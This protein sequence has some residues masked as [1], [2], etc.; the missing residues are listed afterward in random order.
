MQVSCLMF[1]IGTVRVDGASRFGMRRFTGSMELT[2]M[3]TFPVLRGPESLRFCHSTLPFQGKYVKLMTNGV[4]E[5]N[6][7]RYPIHKTSQN[8]MPPVRQIGP[9]QISY[10]PDGTSSAMI[11]TEPY[12]EGQILDPLP[13]ET[14]LTG[15]PYEIVKKNDETKRSYFSCGRLKMHFESFPAGKDY[16]CGSAAAIDKNLLITAAHNFFPSHFSD[17]VANHEK[18]RAN[19]VNFEHLLLVDDDRRGSYHIHLA[20]HCYMHPEWEKSFDHRYDIALVFLSQ[21]ITLTQQES[22][23]LLK[24]QVLPDSVRGVIRIVGYPNARSMMRAST[25][26]LGDGNDASKVIY[27]RANTHG[28]S[29]SPIINNNKTIIGIHAYGTPGG[30]SSATDHNSR[31]RIRN[32]ILPF[33]EESIRLN[34]IFLEDEEKAIGEKTKVQ[35]RYEA[36]KAEKYRNEEKA[37]GKLEGKL[38]V[39]RNMKK[40]GLSIDTISKLTGLSVDDLK[41]LYK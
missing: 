10:H 1:L 8:L 30:A 18:I 3:Q 5:I 39:A 7:P 35:E 20:S 13:V 9:A 40:D 36:E 27:H 41:I 17:G 16:F 4:V 2:S 14:Q 25:G 15:D 33:I 23:E 19:T 32:D 11:P 28:S 12:P 34:Q 38:E 26:I 24:L 21:C 37:K 31:V 29:G 22:D 6:Q